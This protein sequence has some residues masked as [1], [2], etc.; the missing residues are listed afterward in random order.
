MIPE[1]LLEPVQLMLDRGVVNS[2]TAEALC[3]RLEGRVM[4]L[5]PGAEGLTNGLAMY[6]Q[7]SEGRLQLKSGTAETPDT[8]LS[9]SLLNLARLGG[10]DPEAAIREGAVNISGATEIADDFRALLNMTR[11]DWEEE[12]SKLTGD[13]VAHEAG[14]AVRGFAGWASRAR[15]SLGRSVAEYLT[16]ESRDLVASAELE[17]FYTDVD[18]L[19]M[20]VDRAAA[21]LQQLRTHKAKQQEKINE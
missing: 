15:E 1:V 13:V 10:A 17:E 11:P 14:R 21:K 7:V 12:L 16:E 3:V 5:Q 2:T 6:F 19:S 9:G 20:G 4:Q 18:Q 8:T